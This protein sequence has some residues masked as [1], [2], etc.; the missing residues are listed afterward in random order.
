VAFTAD[1]RPEQL[2][3]WVREGV[4][5]FVDRS[6]LPRK[7]PLDR[8]RALGCEL[9]KVPD[10]PWLGKLVLASTGR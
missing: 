5:V 3:A 1:E 7:F 2:A 6:I 8:V 4:P 9:E 10:R